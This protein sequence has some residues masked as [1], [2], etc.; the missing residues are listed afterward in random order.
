MPV[1]GFSNGKSLDN[2]PQANKGGHKGDTR[3]AH[4]TRVC[5]N[6]PCTL[7]QAALHLQT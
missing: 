5:T 7:G 1:L 2:S 6:H 3:K 4:L